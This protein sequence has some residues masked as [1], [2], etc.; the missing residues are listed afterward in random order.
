MPATTEIEVFNFEGNLEK[1]FSDWFASK[2][3]TLYTAN[4]IEV[5]PDSY[6][7]PTV[8]INGATGKTIQKPSGDNEYS[9]YTFDVAF[10]IET[11]R[12]EGTPSQ[13]A[14]IATRHAE[15]VAICRRWLAVSNAR[16]N[17]DSYFPLY[18][19]DTLTPGSSERDVS[20]DDDSDVTILNYS[21]QFTI[22]TTA[23]PV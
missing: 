23:F 1:G 5:L 14:E 2:T 15:V 16:G 6:I 11:E 20:D 12:G 9:Q 13:T 7:A 17:I 10:R 3:V 21:G 22:L 8:S 4:S 19:I 18:Q